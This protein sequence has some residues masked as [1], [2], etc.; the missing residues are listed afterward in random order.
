LDR[1]PNILL[2]ILDDKQKKADRAL[3]H[4]AMGINASVGTRASSLRLQTWNG[5]EGLQVTWTSAQKQQVEPWTPED[6]EEGLKKP[7]TRL[8]MQRSGGDRAHEMWEVVSKYHVQ[9]MMFGGKNARDHEEIALHQR[10]ALCPVP[11]WVNDKAPDPFE[12]RWETH[13]SGLVES[14]RA[15]VGIWPEQGL[16]VEK[17]L[18]QTNP[19]L[20][21]FRPLARKFAAQT[22]GLDPKMLCSL[23]LAVPDFTRT[24]RHL[25]A[26][27]VVDGVLLQR[28]SFPDLDYWGVAIFDAGELSTDLSTFEFIV[29]EKLTALL[30]TVKAGLGELEKLVPVEDDV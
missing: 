20:P 25:D 15:M 28:L 10:A 18:A 14:M 29:D 7:V 22:L 21:G 1:I 30:G 19:D 13:P 16:A 11:V 3:L 9:D 2:N 4:L 17:Y 23:Y 5:S 26:Y 6:E 12:L 24:E 27:L 8:E